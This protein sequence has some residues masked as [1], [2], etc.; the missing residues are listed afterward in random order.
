MIESKHTQGPWRV[1]GADRKGCS[2][3][4]IWATSI[5]FHLA[6]CER[7]NESGEIPLESMKANALLISAAPEMLLAMQTCVTI[8]STGHIS[9]KS[10]R[11]INHFETI[12]AKATTHA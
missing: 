11:I 7:E 5:D 6:T 2:C 4:Q 12:I 3:G 8:L 10:K 1:C 9:Y